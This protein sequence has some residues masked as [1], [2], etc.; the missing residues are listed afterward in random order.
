MWFNRS[1]AD[2][3]GLVLFLATGAAVAEEPPFIPDSIPDVTTVDAEGLLETFDKMPGLLMIDARIAMDRQQGFIEG[4]ISL[5]DVET[6]CNALGVHIPALD[7]PTL[8]YCNGLKCGRSVKSI[9]TAK[10]CGY[11]NLYWF[12]GGFEEW[13]SKA[14]P[15]LKE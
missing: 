7:S 14:Y 3:F 11:T 5:P 15:F 6:D 9:Y 4:S 1:R 12:R 13:S 10:D 8:F 2:I